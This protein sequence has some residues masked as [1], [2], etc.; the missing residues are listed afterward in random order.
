M[1]YEGKYK[2]IMCLVFSCNNYLLRAKE[3]R[4]V[5]RNNENSHYHIKRK[6]FHPNSE[7]QILAR[8]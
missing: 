2:L 6:H 5:S 7:L 8:S 3:S 4:I 1:S